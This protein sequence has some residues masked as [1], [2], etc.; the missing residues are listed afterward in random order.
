MRAMK[1]ERSFYPHHVAGFNIYRSK[2]DRESR[3]QNSPL[4]RCVVAAV[5]ARGQN[6][7]ER[8]NVYHEELERHAQE[9]EE[10]LS[11]EGMV[12]PRP[13]TPPSPSEIEKYV[14]KC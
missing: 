4:Q 11:R 6:D 8:W 9:R 13:P 3:L 2:Y 1:F 14:E 5:P 10:A 7:D 12:P